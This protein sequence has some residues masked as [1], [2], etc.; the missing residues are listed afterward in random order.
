[1]VRGPTAR[2]RTPVLDVSSSGRSPRGSAIIDRHRQKAREH[3]IVEDFYDLGLAL[4]ERLDD[5]L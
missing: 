1:L 4:E 5:A 2:P 3:R